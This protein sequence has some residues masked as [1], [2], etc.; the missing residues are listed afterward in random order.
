MVRVFARLRFYHANVEAGYSWLSNEY[1]LVVDTAVGFEVV[2]PSGEI[3]QASTESNP[4]LF[5]ALKGG[6]NN[7]VSS[8]NA[9]GNTVR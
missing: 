7:F 2:L 9:P 1:G 4:D 8:N 3:V 6:F 5:F